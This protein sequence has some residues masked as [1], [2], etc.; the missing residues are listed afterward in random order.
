MAVTAA[1]ITTTSTTIIITTIL[2]T[3]RRLSAKQ[4]AI[5]GDVGRTV[6]NQPLIIV[7]PNCPLTP[8]APGFIIPGAFCRRLPTNIKRRW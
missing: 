7:W 8:E 5:I 4:F 2:I 1:V 3:R 6:T